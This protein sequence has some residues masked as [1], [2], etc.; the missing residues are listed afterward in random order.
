MARVFDAPMEQNEP[1][2]AYKVVE[3][4]GPF[5]REISQFDNKTKTIIKT[6]V[7]Y[8]NG[9]MVFFPKGHSHMYPSLDALRRAGFGEIV[10]LIN[11]RLDGEINKDLP[12]KTIRQ[13]IEKAIKGEDK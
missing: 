2:P 12:Q 10:P 6:E 5:T 3:M 13:P 11:M 7:S 8:E 4:E 9:Y 1:I